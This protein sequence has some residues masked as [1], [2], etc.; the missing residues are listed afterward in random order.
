MKSVR[1]QSGRVMCKSQ[2]IKLIW[3]KGA[4]FL[5]P[6]LLIVKPNSS[7]STGGHTLVDRA[8]LPWVNDWCCRTTTSQAEGMPWRLSTQSQVSH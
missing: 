7:K 4:L 1:I 8:M 6:T 2:L 5:K 3:G